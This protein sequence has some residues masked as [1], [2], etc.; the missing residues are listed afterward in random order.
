MALRRRRRPSGEPPPLPRDLHRTGVG[1]VAATVV[2]VATWGLILSGGERA[3]Y[4]DRFDISIVRWV[5][6][7]RFDAATT[8][9]KALH[10]LGSD[11]TLRAIAWS[12]VLGGLAFKRFR[13]VLVFLLSV[14]SVSWV[15]STVAG[16]LTRPRP[17]GVEI[18]GDWQG[19]SHPSRVVADLCVGLLGI[20][21]VM[22]EQGPW[23]QRFKWLAGG[24]IVALAGSR[25]YLGVDHPTDVMFGAV[26]GVAITLV[27]FRTLTPNE[28]F[29]VT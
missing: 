23:R 5:A 10:A 14:L 28:A 25:V 21:Y 24:A 19:Y 9:A 11:W 27:A 18:I 22:I 6:D 4:V 20:A 7:L 29:P 8:V 12:V 16:V 3:L 17:Y 13:H 1:W 15:T 26:I 2:V